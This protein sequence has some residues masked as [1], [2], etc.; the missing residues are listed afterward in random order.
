MFTYGM[1][2]MPAC[3]VCGAPEMSCGGRGV[4]PRGAIGSGMF[5]AGGPAVPEFPWRSRVSVTETDP[6]TGGTVQKYGIGTPVPLLEA[7]RQGIVRFE[8]LGPAE[9][10]ALEA[11][12]IKPPPK[13]GPL[14]ERPAEESVKRGGAAGTKSPDAPEKDKMVR[15]ESVRRK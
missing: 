7:L 15:R 12:G 9:V 4:A 2:R 6:R 14:T 1:G 8:D 5:L 10:S 13:D 11:H 3:P